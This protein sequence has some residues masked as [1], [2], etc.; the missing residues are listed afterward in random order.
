MALAAF[1]A[2]EDGVPD[3]AV[4]NGGVP[5]ISVLLGDGTASFGSRADFTFG[6]YP[7]SI[8]AADFNA[9]DHVDCVLAHGTYGYPY[10]LGTLTIALSTGTGSFGTPV[11]FGGASDYSWVVAGDLD[12]DGALDIAATQAGSGRVAIFMGKGNG[13]FEAGALLATNPNPSCVAVDD[14]D[15]DGALDLVVS[16]FDYYNGTISVLIGNGDGTFQPKV[17]YAVGSAPTYT[18]LHDLNGDGKLDVI[19]SNSGVASHS[20]TVLL[21]AGDG[22]FGDRRDLVLAG[23]PQGITVGDFDQDA[24]PDLAVSAGNVVL[25]FRGLGD[26]TFAP[27]QEFPSPRGSIGS[28]ALDADNDGR[29][30][31]LVAGHIPGALGVLLGNGDGTFGTAPRYAS[32]AGPFSPN[33]VDMDGDVHLDVVVSHYGGNPGQ[34]RQG[35]VLRGL[36]D[37]SLGA[38]LEFT[39]GPTPGSVA[40]AD[41]TGDGKPDVA[42]ID[43]QGVSLLVGTG[44]GTLSPPQP[45]LALPNAS[46]VTAADVNR[47]SKV[48]LIMGAF[49]SDTARVTVLLGD[50]QGG[51]GPRLDLETPS[52]TP[53]AA[54]ADVTQDGVPDLITLNPAGSTVQIFSGYGNGGFELSGEYGVGT[55]AREIAVADFN[56]DAIPDLAV[57]NSYSYPLSTVTVL[58]GQG[59]GL[60]GAGV[61]L[62]AGSGPGRIVT[63]DFDGNGTADLVTANADANTISVFSG[64]GNGQFAPRVDLGVGPVPV[65]LAVGDMDEDGRPDLV[66][67]ASTI[68]VLQNRT[69]EVTTAANLA[70]MSAE[71][72]PNLVRIRWYVRRDPGTESHV[73]RRTT[74]TDWEFLGTPQAG[75]GPILTFEDRTVVG[76]SKYGYRLVVQG[77]RGLESIETWI[78]VPAGATTPSVPHLEPIHPNPISDYGALTY[79]L[80]APGRVRLSVFDLRGRLVRTV[81]DRF[82]PANSRTVVWD[83]RDGRGRSVSSG[84]Y[85]ARLEAGGAVL[86]RKIVVMR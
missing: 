78:E 59:S 32:L 82:E 28:V 6:Y 53:D 83:G 69:A 39:I 40:A 23:I 16:H 65:G 5:G 66:V 25:M 51:F 75:A 4:A 27:G 73:D 67:T 9:D 18:T 58:L 38:P 24:H 45:L 30:D 62:P 70:T 52:A 21:G 71:A 26:G 74:E 61:T 36:G 41:F 60:F 48:D 1:D 43:Y 79:S 11:S 31:L 77:S 54:I 68:W 12:G 2:N 85:F 20:V 19:V 81:I 35:S 22:T 72:E 33:V 64:L 47:D 57:A 13:T 63:L 46:F 42:A 14:V 55:E 56:G 34:A 86:V 37:G 44:G 29:L 80:P 7:R 8:V 10:T 49:P 76:G 84:A 17:D 15:S 50:G 3:V